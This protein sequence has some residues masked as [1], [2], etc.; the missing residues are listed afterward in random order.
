MTERSNVSKCWPLAGHHKEM[1]SDYRFHVTRAARRSISDYLDRSIEPCSIP[2]GQ[3]PELR[4]HS[5]TRLA[6][7]SPNEF[8]M[9]RI[10]HLIGI[11]YLRNHPIITAEMNINF[12]LRK[13]KTTHA[14]LFK[15]GFPLA[16][17]R[18]DRFRLK[19]TKLAKWSAIYIFGTQECALVN[20]NKFIL[21]Y[22]DCARKSPN[23]TVLISSGES[24]RSS[25]VQ[26]WTRTHSLGY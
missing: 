22:A 8:I 4:P 25:S 13:L 3:F 17:V 1:V 12:P 10:K 23:L 6:A 5:L 20:R 11:I 15:L 14:N 26:S 16:R 7:P 2:T 18:I 21:C 19:H 24:S 9:S